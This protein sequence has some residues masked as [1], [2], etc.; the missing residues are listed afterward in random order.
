MVIN[1]VNNMKIYL[2]LSGFFFKFGNGRK[3]F[4]FFGVMGRIKGMKMGKGGI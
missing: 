2:I 3:I 4:I 1:K